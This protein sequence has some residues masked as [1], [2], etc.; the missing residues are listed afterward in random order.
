MKIGEGGAASE[1]PGL[2]TSDISLF[3]KLFVVGYD[4]HLRKRESI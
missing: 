3:I 4:I 1:G 2:L